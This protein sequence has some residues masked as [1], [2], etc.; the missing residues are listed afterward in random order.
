MQTSIFLAR[1]I[2]PIVLI[3]GIGM[4]T[5]QAVYRQIA[6]ESLASHALV[7]LNGLLTGAAGLAIVLAHNVWEPD[8][9]LLITLLGWFVAI[10]GA[11]RILVPQA[12][13]QHGSRIVTRPTSVTITG[14]VYLVIGLVLC[15]FGYLRQLV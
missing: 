3:A 15:F 6:E 4:L 7:Y 11:V 5:H 2:G 13:R 12:T 1:L 10:G 9:R 14:I 8:W